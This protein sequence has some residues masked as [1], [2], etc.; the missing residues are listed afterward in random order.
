MGVTVFF[1]LVALAVT[2]PGAN[3]SP[4]STVHPDNLK[5]KPLTTRLHISEHGTNFNETVTF[6]PANH[7]V[8][9]HVPKHHRLQEHITIMDNITRKSLTYLPEQSQCQLKNIPDHLDPEGT[10]R[11]LSAIEP[12]HPVAT[13]EASLTRTYAEVNMGLATSKDL[14]GLPQ[15]MRDLCK[16]LPIH[17]VQQIEVDGDGDASAEAVKQ[18]LNSQLPKRVK[19]DSCGMTWE[20]V[21]VGDCGDC[22][23]CL[24]TVCPVANPGQHCFNYGKSRFMEH[25]WTNGIFAS[26]LC[27][28]G[29]D[30]LPFLCSC[31]YVNSQEMGSDEYKRRF[32]ACQDKY[33]GSANFRPYTGQVIDN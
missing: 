30:T 4:H 22:Y 20:V 21:S 33:G 3:S 8:T 12:L 32:K 6:N 29:D 7:L 28:D 10:F 16:N 5:S 26:V 23:T 9:F 27:C 18:H 31:D 25:Y 24:Y 11:T 13:P 15:E 2:L 14:L 19:R 17:R 1:A